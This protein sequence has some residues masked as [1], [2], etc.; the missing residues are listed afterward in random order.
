MGY[1]YEISIPDGTM[2]NTK[3]IAGISSGDFRIFIYACG[4]DLK[5]P[6]N[7]NI[8]YIQSPDVLGKLEC[9]VGNLPKEVE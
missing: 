4:F 9:R 5:Y 3:A 8:N 7:I 1:S 2:M 6:L